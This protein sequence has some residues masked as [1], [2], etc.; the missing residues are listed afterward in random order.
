MVFFM[1]HNICCSFPLAEM[2]KDHQ[3]DE[4]LLTVL[5]MPRKNENLLKYA[6]FIEDKETQEPKHYFAEN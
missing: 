1:D 5:G 6:Y 3:R 2:V 4:R